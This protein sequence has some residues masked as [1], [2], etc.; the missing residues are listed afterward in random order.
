MKDME[1]IHDFTDV[2]RLWGDVATK[3]DN[4]FAE[5]AGKTGA[6]ADLGRV[7]SDDE[8]FAQAA[9]LAGNTGVCLISW[10]TDIESGYI[11]QSAIT[12][13][14]VMQL[15]LATDANGTSYMRKVQD[16]EAGK[17]TEWPTG[18]VDEPSVEAD[19]DTVTLKNGDT[20]LFE[21][22]GATEEQAGIVT[23]DDYSRMLNKQVVNMGDVPNEEGLIEKIKIL[24]D[25]N[26]PRIVVYERGKGDGATYYQGWL[27]LFNNVNGLKKHVVCF[28]ASGND[29]SYKN[30]CVYNFN[31]KGT[32]AWEYVNKF[33]LGDGAVAQEALEAAGAAQT[34]AEGA[35]RTAETANTTAGAAKTA[36]DGAV[37]DAQAAQTAA[38]SASQTANTASQTANTAKQT[39]DTAKSTADTAKQTADTAKS[40]ADTA[41]QTAEGAKASAEG[42]TWD[43]TAMGLSQSFLADYAGTGE[44][45][46]AGAEAVSVLTSTLKKDELVPW[47]GW[48]TLV[49]C[50]T[51]EDANA[52]ICAVGKHGESAEQVIVPLTKVS[53]G[54][55]VVAKL[56]ADP[57]TRTVT[58]EGGDAVEVRKLTTTGALTLHWAILY[59]SDPYGNPRRRGGSEREMIEGVLNSYV[60]TGIHTGGISKARY[61]ERT[62]W[63][64]VNGLTDM[65]F[66][67]CLAVLGD[68][69]PKV[70]I[71][72]LNNDFTSS[73]RTNNAL[74]GIYDSRINFNFVNGCGEVICLGPQL[75]DNLFGFLYNNSNNG[76]IAILSY[77]RFQSN[78]TQGTSEINAVNLETVDFR[79]LHTNLSVKNLA[80][81]SYETF[82]FMIEFATNSA[83]ITVTVHADVY[84]KMTGG[85]VD[86]W[87]SLGTLAEG[88]GVKLI[89]YGESGYPFLTRVLWHGYKRLENKINAAKSGD[90][91]YIH[92]DDRRKITEAQ[93][94]DWA[95]LVT[96]GAEKQISF[97][98]PA[99]S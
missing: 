46:A 13:S 62:G 18:G 69:A 51:T 8:A 88:K 49:A 75:R 61:N 97:A 33:E 12:P 50:Y 32:D 7:A 30:L 2:R 55:R 39:A 27:M 89:S 9:V 29:T 86:D 23:A 14:V 79:D 76:V 40:T 20:H 4:N 71:E 31:H 57:G 52:Q 77:I 66:D 34:T 64:E 72:A 59:E 21:I 95:A 67:D 19:A 60:N 73:A 6:L 93:R 78:F 92:P 26:T 1:K 82:R 54:E 70:K 56:T 41:K 44:P 63:F 91:I 22:G 43:V 48:F 35:Q 85:T 65:T 87:G 84:G 98:L 94:D 83:A 99:E 96:A 68:F 80:S 74:Q 25:L 28:E 10:H 42:L 58:L 90:V 3:I 53:A 37:K 45:V 36:A 81:L 47:H 5:L 17:W 15:R 11:L 16:G 24:C 38:S